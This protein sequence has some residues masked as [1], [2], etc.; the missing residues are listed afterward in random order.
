MKDIDEDEF[1][2]FPKPAVLIFQTLNNFLVIKVTFFHKFLNVRKPLA[3]S[4]E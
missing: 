1:K 2:M 4:G 3:S